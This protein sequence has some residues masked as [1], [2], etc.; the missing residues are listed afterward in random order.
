MVEEREAEAPDHLKDASR[1]AED[2]GHGKGY[3]YPH[4]YRDHWVAQQYLPTSL[5]RPASSTSRA[6]WAA[7]ARFGMT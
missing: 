6:A 7:S 1:D 4:A 2:M 5:Q 3:L